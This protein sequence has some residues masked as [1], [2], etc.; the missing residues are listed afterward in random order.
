MGLAPMR[1]LIHICGSRIILITPCLTVRVGTDFANPA[2]F[3]ACRHD[4]G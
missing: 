1:R 2:A 4:T 3:V